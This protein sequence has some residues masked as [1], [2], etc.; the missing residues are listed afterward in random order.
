M[1]K[2]RNVLLAVAACTLL[3]GAASVVYAP[4]VFAAYEEQRAV[5][6]CGDLAQENLQVDCWMKIV[7]DTLKSKGIP[8]TYKVFARIYDAYPQFGATGCHVHAHRIGDTAY[9]TFMVDQGKTLDEI[10]FPVETTTCGYGF[11]HGFIEHLVQDHPKPEFVTETCEYLRGRLTATMRDIGT[12]CYHAS[13]HGFAVAQADHMK[14]GQYGNMIALATPA[15]EACEKL[16]TASETEKEDCREGI[17][18]VTSDWA[19]T[20]NFGL[21]INYEHPFWE[22]DRLSKRWRYACYYEYGMKLRPITGEDPLR[23]EKLAFGIRDA[24]LREMAFGVMVAGMMQELAPE[25]RYKEAAVGCSQVGDELFHMCIQSALS[26]LME[27]GSPQ[28]EYV[29]ALKFCKDPALVERN[30]GTQCFEALQFRLRRFYSKEKKD[31]ICKEFP[32]DLVRAC[33]ALR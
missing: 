16:S 6:K 7:L 11:W 27:H 26:G 9:Y 17:F 22:C 32:S 10:D 2:N 33:V 19:S 21:A 3:A 14:P 31:E 29:E 5:S 8:D 24:D 28:N 20:Q 4:R 18:N 15:L 13:G 1:L 25:G 23:A 12:I 30:G